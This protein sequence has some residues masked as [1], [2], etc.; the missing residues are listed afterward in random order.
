MKAALYARVS[1]DDLSQDPE[2]QLQPLRAYAASMG[3]VVVAEW[4]DYASGGNS[5]RPAFTDMRKHIRQR[6][7]DVVLVWALD[8]F[9]RESMHNTLAYIEELKHYKTGLKSLQESWLDT[10]AGGVGDLMLAVFA[11]VAEQERL[12]ISER[13]KAGLAKARAEGK[14]LGRPRKNKDVVK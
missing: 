10:T 12:R 2:N 1:K 7:Y 9:S 8:R 11:W 6:H 14:V 3:Y 4:V 5:A 13:T